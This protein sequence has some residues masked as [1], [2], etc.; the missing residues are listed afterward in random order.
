MRLFLLQLLLLR[1][2]FVLVLLKLRADM[3]Q[4]LEFGCMFAT[5]SH[6]CL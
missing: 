1:R 4:L 5:A 6:I 3:L 2:E